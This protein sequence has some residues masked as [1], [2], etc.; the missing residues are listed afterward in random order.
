MEDYADSLAGYRVKKSDNASSQAKSR[1]SGY[2][3]S[4]QKLKNL[5]GHPLSQ[6]SVTGA[7]SNAP[8]QNLNGYRKSQRVAQN[9]SSM[10]QQNADSRNLGAN[11]NIQMWINK[12]GSGFYSP[13]NTRAR[14]VQS[15]RKS[16]AVEGGKMSKNQIDALEEQVFNHLSKKIFGAAH[17]DAQDKETLK[18]L[19]NYTVKK[20]ISQKVDLLN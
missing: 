19:C 15:N 8:S 10:S 9:Q 16:M 18:S 2:A 12:T 7:E 4:T 6:G 14:V 5:G 17:T 13:H 1:Y 3:M 11:H 20:E